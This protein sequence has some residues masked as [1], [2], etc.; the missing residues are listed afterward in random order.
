[1]EI[2]VV[3]SMIISILSVTSLSS[4]TRADLSL[5]LVTTVM[6]LNSTFPEKRLYSQNQKRT[7]KVFKNNR[8]PSQKSYIFVCKWLAISN[9][10]CTYTH[11]YGGTTIISWSKTTYN[12]VRWFTGIALLT[13]MILTQLLVFV[14]STEDHSGKIL[15]VEV[16]KL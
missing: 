7:F 2:M 11:T 15:Q 10:S 6:S 5:I 8:V 12:L 3:M 14:Y 16:S 13:N 9:K 1:M 4:T